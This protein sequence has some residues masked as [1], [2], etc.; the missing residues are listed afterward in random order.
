LDLG[1]DFA[2]T[3]SFPSGFAVRADDAAFTVF[4]A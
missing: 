3:K 4:D 2:L 1:A